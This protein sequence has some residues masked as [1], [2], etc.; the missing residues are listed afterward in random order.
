MTASLL[1][2]IPAMHL[3]RDTVLRREFK[4]KHLRT[5]ACAA[6]RHPEVLPAAK[7]RPSPTSLSGS[8]EAAL[9]GYV[10]SAVYIAYVKAV[11]S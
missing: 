2:Q 4:H 3:L 6:L 7:L 10:V 11:G 1:R 8:I 9:S 5:C